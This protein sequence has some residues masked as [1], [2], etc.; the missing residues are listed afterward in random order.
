MAAYAWSFFEK[1]SRHKK[2]WLDPAREAEVGHKVTTGQLNQ[3]Y[4]QAVNTYP[5]RSQQGQLR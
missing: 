3:V 4:S 2:P 1:T 5:N